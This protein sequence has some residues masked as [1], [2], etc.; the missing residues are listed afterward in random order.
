MRTRVV[1][2]DVIDYILEGF[3]HQLLNFIHYIYLIVN[4]L[5]GDE[6]L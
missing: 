2:H 3:L 6:C 1:T 5:A 4:H